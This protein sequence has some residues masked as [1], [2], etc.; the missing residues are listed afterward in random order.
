M[1]SATNVNQRFDGSFIVRKATFDAV[2]LGMRN[3]LVRKL[4]IRDASVPAEV[5]YWI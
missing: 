5:S 1:I 4:Y 3:V 2:C